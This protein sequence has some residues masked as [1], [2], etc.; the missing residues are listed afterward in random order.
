MYE[1]I[2]HIKFVIFME[3]GSFSSYCGKSFQ[4]PKGRRYCEQKCSGNNQNYECPTCG[5][6]FHVKWRLANHMKT[7]TGERNFGCP[8]PGC[9]SAYYCKANLATH[10]KLTHKLDHREVFAQ[11]GGPIKL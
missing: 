8:I 11:Y 4:Y 1:N 3:Y 5:R 7:H 9:T 10:I 6:K 2:H